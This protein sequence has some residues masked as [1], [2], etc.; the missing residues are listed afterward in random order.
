MAQANHTCCL[1]DECDVPASAFSVLLHCLVQLEC[2][3]S[4]SAA[5]HAMGGNLNVVKGTFDSLAAFDS[6]LP[7][8][9]VAACIL[10]TSNT[11]ANLL[12]RHA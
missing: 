4:G 6:T 8:S 12:S 3:L 10:V 9:H 1:A 11:A 7:N 5:C 2:M